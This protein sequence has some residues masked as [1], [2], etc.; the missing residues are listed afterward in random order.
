MFF[1]LVRWE[2]IRV[3]AV[4]G[5]LLLAV[6]AVLAALCLLSFALFRNLFLIVLT[7]ITAACAAGAAVFLAVR[8][9]VRAA[10]GVPALIERELFGERRLL[11]E[12]LEEFNKS[13]RIQDREALRQTLED[14]E[15]KPALRRFHEARWRKFLIQGAVWCGL[16]AVAAALSF[17]FLGPAAQTVSGLSDFF[18]YRLKTAL[19]GV[20][21]AGAPFTADLSADTPYFDSL[22]LTAGGDDLDSSNAVFFITEKHASRSEMTLAVRGSRFGWTRRLGGVTAVATTRLVPVSVRM[23]VRYFAPDEKSGLLPDEE[24]SGLQDLEVWG[25]ARVTVSGEM[26]KEIEGAA[27]YPGPKDAVSFSGRNFECRTDPASGKR[28][29]FR[30]RSRD[31]DVYESVPFLVRRSFNR[32]PELRLVFPAG[33]VL[34]RSYPWTV[35]AVLQG[36]DDQGIRFVRVLTVM[37]NRNPRLS[38]YARKSETRID[39]HNARTWQSAARFLSSELDLLPDE[40]ASVRFTA[41]DVFGL[42]SAPVGFSIVFPDLFDLREEDRRLLSSVSGNLKTASNATLALDEEMRKRDASPNAGLNADQRSRLLQDALSNLTRSV[43]ELS[44]GTFADTA[45]LAETVRMMRDVTEKLARNADILAARVSDAEK[46]RD[47][48]AWKSPEPGRMREYLKDLSRLLDDLERMRSVSDAYT[49]Y[50]IAK[51]LYD[52]LRDRSDSGGFERAREAYRKEIRKLESLTEGAAKELASQLGGEAGKLSGSE[53]NS[54][55]R[56]DELMKRLE[57]QMGQNLRDARA[58]K[59]RERQKTVERAAEELF[60]WILF[61]DEMRSGGFGTGSRPDADRTA[62]LAAVISSVSASYNT[63]RPEI[64]EALGGLVMAPGVRE[65][66]MADMDAVGQRI[67]LF[68]D[69]I[70]DYRVDLFT[71]ELYGLVK[72]VSYLY[73]DL[74]ALKAAM[75]QAARD[76]QSGEG[77]KRAAAM[78]LEDLLR[79]QS[80]VTLQMD[81]LRQQLAREGKLTPEIRSHL[82]E[83]ARL[84]QEIRD[85]LAEMMKNGPGGLFEGG[86]EINKGMEDIIKDLKSFKIEDR[87]LEKSK[88]IEEKLLK[89]RK[90]IE[91]KGVSDERKSDRAKSYD[92]VPPGAIPAGDAGKIDLD[93]IQDKKISEYYKKLIEKYK[94]R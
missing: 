5:L 3:H 43:N 34:I 14:L 47:R 62:E 83:L 38:R 88:T 81:A 85:Q 33:D 24:Y 12:S 46:N 2:K 30:F 39:A 86:T 37:T 41:Q 9:W 4:H 68:L 26:T 48:A 54:F 40:V 93:A 94:K 28:F 36:D 23:T 64:A 52:R 42:S 21:L 56:S 82:E 17:F 78:N 92:V 63:I 31:G 15:K 59:I 75:E 61:L 73:L 22:E 20:Y 16:T 11:L 67:G 44:G 27:L 18:Q 45:E 72:T 91:S 69:L 7:V 50:R 19:P 10:S 51:A 57:E 87:T 70:K 6:A 60:V 13:S 49:Q 76:A 53:R 8:R 90:A 66:V 25:N 84:Q 35:T 65:S 55:Q 1:S 32:A 58:A 74:I 77:P 29:F 89:S 71:G 79:M 80:L